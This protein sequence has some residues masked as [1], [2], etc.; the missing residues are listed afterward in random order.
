MRE[1]GTLSATPGWGGKEN[2]EGEEENPP[3]FNVDC[4]HEDY[5]KAHSSGQAYSNIEV[6]GQGE[7]NGRQH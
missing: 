1:Q 6:R 5:A 2:E 7:R 3:K 4:Q